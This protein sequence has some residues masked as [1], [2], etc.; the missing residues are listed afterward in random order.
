MSHEWKFP[1]KLERNYDGDTFSLELDLG[2]GLRHYTNVRLDGAD[3]PELRGGTAETRALAR[4]AKNEAAHFV[5]GATK[6]LFHSTKWAG[7][8]GRPIG[9]ILCNG[10]SL[11]QYLIRI[12][13]AVPYDGGSRKEIQEVHQENAEWWIAEHGMEVEK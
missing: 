6:V 13:L 11:A 9:D 10:K 8:Y 12:R 1:A 4:K 7:K 3:T 5:G 2:F